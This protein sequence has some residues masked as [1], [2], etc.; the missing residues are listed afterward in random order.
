MTALTVTVGEIFVEIMATIADRWGQE[1]SL[2]LGS[3]LFTPARLA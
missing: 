3:P 2:A 1:E